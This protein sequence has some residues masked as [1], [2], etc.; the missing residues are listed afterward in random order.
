MNHA[1]PPLADRYEQDAQVELAAWQARIVSGPN[2]WDRTTRGV[3]QR[4]NRAIPEKVHT[5]ITATI[6][7]MT[8]GI[9]S[10]SGLT[11]PAPL[12]GAS[13]AQREAKVLEKIALYRTT[14]TA[15]GGV[16]GAGGFLMAAADFPVLISLKIKLL[17]DIAALYG[18]SGKDFRE[19]LYILAIFQLA[20]S[21]PVHRKE[22]FATMAAWDAREVGTLDQFDWRRFQQEYRDYIDLAK[23]AQMLPL[24]GAPVGMIVNYRL[25]DR[26][27]ETAINAYRMRWF[28]GR[29]PS[30][31]AGT[32][33]EIDETRSA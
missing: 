33:T 17:F 12:L 5:V 29:E 11:T 28:E 4:I 10:G 13:L 20:F 6:E 30:L 1:T 15:E 31:Q 26:L 18:H 16:A 27:G 21:S 9:L 19:R 2:L 23:M 24:I 8:R 3:Q 22:V 7:Q 32:Q 14:A 25:L